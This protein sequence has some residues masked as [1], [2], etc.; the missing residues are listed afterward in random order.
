MPDN[1]LDGLDKP[2]F[3]LTEEETNSD[4]DLFSA[5]LRKGL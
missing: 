2:L 4:K 1:Y 5:A 3:D